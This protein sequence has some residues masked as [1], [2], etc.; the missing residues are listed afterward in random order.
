M[1]LPTYVTWRLELSGIRSSAIRQGFRRQACEIL[2]Q[3]RT[4]QC[5][6]SLAATCKGREFGR[7]CQMRLLQ[8]MGLDAATDRYRKFSHARC[9]WVINSVDLGQIRSGDAK[10]VRGLFIHKNG[11]IR[12]S[13]CM[14]SA[15]RSEAS[16]LVDVSSSFLTTVLLINVGSD[17]LPTSD[18]ASLR[19]AS[20]C[21]PLPLRT[22][23]IPRFLITYSSPADR[24]CPRICLK[25]R[26]RY[27]RALCR[28]SAMQRA[29]AMAAVVCQYPLLAAYHELGQLS[30]LCVLASN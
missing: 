26:T 17:S 6:Q 27:V 5:F 12:S 15:G 8:I 18:S 21:Q 28:L 23:R 22:K 1:A 4:I 9:R 14:S 3:A 20:V 25:V 2:R 10:Q 16:D 13:P 30:T 24:R 11:I 7:E 29:K 19:G